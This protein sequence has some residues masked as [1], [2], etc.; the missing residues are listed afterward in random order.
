MSDVTKDEAIEVLKDLWRYEKS[1]YSEKQIR[2]ALDMATEALETQKT[3][4]WIADVDKWG[5]VITTI[6]GYKCSECCK[7]NDDKDNYCPNCGADMRGE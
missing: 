2:K 4:H 7:F 3:G 5:G 6:N 1:K